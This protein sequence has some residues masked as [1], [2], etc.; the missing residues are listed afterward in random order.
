MVSPGVRHS[1]GQ[2]SRIPK[3]K[4]YNFLLDDGALF[5]H[6]NKGE[7]LSDAGAQE[8]RDPVQ[9]LSDVGRSAL[10]ADQLGASALWVGSALLRKL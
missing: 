10:W 3:H 6:H 7:V 2:S 5:M 1:G 9:V 8:P 4:Y